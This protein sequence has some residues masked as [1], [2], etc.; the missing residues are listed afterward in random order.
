MNRSVVVR[1]LPELDRA[2]AREIVISDLHGNLDLYRKLL[3]KCG[4]RHGF[5]R[6][7]LGGDLVEKGP[8]NLNLLH[9]VMDQVKT[10]DVWCLMGN[11]DFT[12]KNVLYS[13][14]PEFLKSVVSSRRSLITEMADILGISMQDM[15]MDEFCHRLRQAWLPE[16]SFLADLPHVLENSQRIYTHAAIMDEKQFGSDF[17]EVM[18]TPFFLH[19]EKRFS[20]PVVCGHMPVSEYRTRTIDFSCIYDAARN[21]WSID[22]GNIVK[23]SGQLNALIFEGDSVSTVSA[24]DLPEAFVLKD[25]DPGVQIPFA[26]S[27]NHRDITVLEKDET[28][29]LVHSDYLHR[30][31]WVP[32]AF[33]ESGTVSEYTNYRMPV[34]K[35]QKVSVVMHCADQVLIKKN[36]VLGWVDAA[37]L[38]PLAG[39]EPQSAL[40]DFEQNHISYS[41]SE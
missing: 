6:L 37:I 17:R 14:R 7:I 31:F 33:L 36:S 40:H 19:T 5:D 32:N 13:Y 9:F 41:D 20:R 11:C 3:A 30:S 27:W 34:E 18:T 10:G 23:R 24:D 4:Y 28:S 22:G 15:D 16:L 29:T 21:I 26:M 35:G 1:H 38:Q 8:Q 39:Q 25:A 2:G 12:A